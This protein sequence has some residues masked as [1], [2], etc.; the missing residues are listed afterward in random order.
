MPSLDEVITLIHQIRDEKLLND[1]CGYPPGGVGVKG[2]IGEKGKVG[3]LNG[4]MTSLTE[5]YA[6]V[7]LGECLT[8]WT[9]SVGLVD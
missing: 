7:E 1:E 5:L 8:Q 4:Y 9:G 2:K 6:A 3:E